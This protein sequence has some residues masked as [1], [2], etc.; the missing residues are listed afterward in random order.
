MERPVSPRLVEGRIEAD[1]T[2]LGRAIRRILAEADWHAVSRNAQSPW[3][4]RRAELSPLKATAFVLTVMPGAWLA[5]LA[6]TGGLTP[7][8]WVFLIYTTGIWALWLFLASLAV[9]PVRQ[10]F[11]WSELV[12]VRPHVSTSAESLA[13]TVL[14]I[15][16]YVWLDRF[17]LGFIINEYETRLT[18]WVATLATAGI[19][20]LGATSL[21]AAIRRM[22]SAAWTQLHY[23]AYPAIGL[24]AIHFDMSPASLGGP[25]YLITGMYFWLMAWRVLQH[26]RLGNRPLVLTGLALAA[27]L[28]SFAFEIAWL[29]PVYQGISADKTLGFTLDISDGLEPT[30]QLLEIARALR[31]GARRH[32]RAEIR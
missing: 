25:M 17:S 29:A 3:L 22:G 8:P 4:N 5:W 23:L 24:A 30:W 13:Y 10:I 27:P 18:V 32:L 1:L 26:Y 20:I 28:A 14:H 11:G 21:D 31:G 7:L 6:I 19:F 2:R 16:D 12:A 15:L 9:T